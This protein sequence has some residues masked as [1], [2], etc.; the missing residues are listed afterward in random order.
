MTPRSRSPIALPNLWHAGIHRAAAFAS[1]DL[2]LLTLMHPRELSGE[3]VLRLPGEGPCDGEP[4]SRRT[5]HV[6][7]A[8]RAV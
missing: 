4:L 3:M 1:R 7:A 8:R 6:R 2:G 5:K